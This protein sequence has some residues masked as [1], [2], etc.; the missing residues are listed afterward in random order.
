VLIEED[1]MAGVLFEIEKGLKE[2]LKKD[3]PEFRVGDTIKLTYKIKEKD[4]E[5][6]HAIEG[7]VIK[8]TNAMHRR[9]VTIRRISYGVGM[10]V[11]FPLYSPLLEKIEVTVP[12]KRRARRARLYYLRGRIGK[13]ATTV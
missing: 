6:S 1:V 10:E 8:E 4:K 11:L 12:A 5:R 9:A 7:L 3:L 2:S 13:Q